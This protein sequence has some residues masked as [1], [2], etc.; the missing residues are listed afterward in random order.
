MGFM[1][2]ELWRADL[3][4]GRN[5]PLCRVRSSQASTS[6]RMDGAKLSRRV[7]N[8]G[9]LFPRFGRDD[10]LYYTALEGNVNFLYRI[11]LCGYCSVDWSPDTRRL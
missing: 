1:S 9:G 11:D 8:I 5:E 7:P 4:T 6:P 2:G 10:G 3:P